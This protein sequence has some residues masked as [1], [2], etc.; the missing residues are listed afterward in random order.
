MLCKD[1]MTSDVE[2]VSAQTSIRDAARKMRDKN[3]GFLP[4]CDDKNCVIG[5]VTDR[6]IAIRAMAEDQPGT[7]LVG[8]VLT[9]EVVACRP[10]DD[11]NYA[12]ELMAQHRKS[13]IM[14]ISRTGRIEGVISLSDIA[15][16]DEGEGGS[17]LRNV[18][19]RE[20]HRRAGALDWALPI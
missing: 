9:P 1:L 6:D 4:V 2:C 8:A 10:G 17:T 14:C 15:Q 3:V 11:L 19:A 20:S 13:R 7:T 5:T 12:R 18:S 16:L